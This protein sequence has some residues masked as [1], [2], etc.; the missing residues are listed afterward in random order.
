ME[1]VVRFNMWEEECPP[2]DTCYDYGKCRC[3]ECIV[4][5]RAKQRERYAK[6][7]AAA[8]G[9]EWDNPLI[10]AHEVRAH[11][12]ELQKQGMGTYII[13]REAG[14]T[15]QGIQKIIQGK[16]V[17]RVRK[18]TAV[19]IMAVVYSKEWTPAVGIAQRKLLELGLEGVSIP[20]IA[21]EIGCCTRTLME[22]RKAR[23]KR[24]RRETFDALM[25]I[26]PNHYPRDSRVVTHTRK[27]KKEFDERNKQEEETWQESIT[28]T[29]C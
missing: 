24:I 20:V 12:R 6:R 2:C 19:K 5:K 11:I 14:M 10:P 16:N 26:N 8:L 29:T 9:E 25:A 17:G 28:Q 1:H 15:E 23:P 21:A 4:A 7:R 27:L 18:Q 22:I 3:E 13:A